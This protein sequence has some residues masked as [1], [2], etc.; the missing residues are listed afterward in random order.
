MA[1]VAPAARSVGADARRGLGPRGA[2]ALVL[3]LA[4][5]VILYAGREVVFLGDEWGWIFSGLH[6]GPDTLL[7]ADNGHLLALNQAVYNVLFRTLGLGDYWVYRV[8][9]LL[10]HLAV[11]MFVFLLARRRLGPGLA[12]ALAATIALLGTGADA[13]LS[14]INLGLLGATAASLA[15]LVM[16]DRGTRRADVAACALLV[17]GLLSWTSAVAYTAGVLVEVLLERNRWRR[18][19][20]PLLPAALYVAWRLHWGGGLF[21]DVGRSSHAPGGIIDVVGHGLQVATGAVA[22]LSGVQL[23]SPTLTHHLPWLRTMAEVVVVLGATALVWLVVRRR[24]LTPRLAN[25]VVNGLLLWLLLAVA[26]GSLGDLYASRYVYAGAIVSALIMVEV[27]A[28]QAWSPRV[29]RFVIVGITIS[30]ALNV[31]WMVVWGNHLRQESTVARAQ[32]AALDIAGRQVPPLF[33]PSRKFALVDVTAADYFRAVRAFGGSP[34]F[35]TTELSTAPEQS[36]EAADAVLARALN[37][38]LTRGGSARGG[39]SPAARRSGGVRIAR[40]GS[41]LTMTPEKAAGMVEITAQSASRLVLESQAG[42]GVLIQARR[43]ANRY[44]VGVGG[45]RGGTRPA[46]LVA[47]LGGVPDPWHFRLFLSGPARVCSSS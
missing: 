19:W 27:F 12:V 34:A 18:I 14:A 24:R 11:A 46:T 16:L 9:A 45:L 21:G 4:A 5:V 32:L 35:T 43:F 6:L 25:L 1:L 47:P 15:A 13:F 41:C 17:I 23:L 40:Q 26:R 10:V 20:V 42:G 7:R 44:T 3:A 39:R 31:G 30:V 29:L 22:G 2:V 37:V 33:R 38:R 36:R 28:D 8:V